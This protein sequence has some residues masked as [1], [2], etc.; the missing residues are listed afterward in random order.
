MIM[1][2]LVST[3]LISTLSFN[4]SAGDTMTVE[5]VIYDNKA[6]AYFDKSMDVDVLAEGF[7]WAE[8]AF[9]VEQLDAVIFSDISTDKVHSWNEAT[10]LTDYLFPSGHA[11][12][13]K[14]NAWRGSNGLTVDNDGKLVLAQQGNRTM[15]RMIAPMSDPAPEYDFLATA[16][17]GEPLN[18]PNDLIVHSSGDIYFTDP[19]YGHEGFENSPN[20]KLDFFGVFRLTPDNE[21]IAIN[22]ELDKPNGIA[23]S[24][25]ESVLYVSDSE[26][27][28]AHIYALALDKEGDAAKAELFFDGSG[29][30]KDGPGST[31]GMIMH[32]DG[33]LITSIP[34]GIGILSTEGELMAKLALGQVTNLALD[35]GTGYLYITAPKQLLRVKL[36]Q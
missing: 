36:K 7:G 26:H 29:L 31:D 14:G 20:I 24:L 2:T 30:I 6:L 16:F 18:S 12:D 8:G 28:K 23:L 25:D 32:P 33:M 3:L 21:L 4:V 10:G 34:N 27:D 11:P 13:D 19:P 22:R 1:R 15:A 5:P 35:P 9:W 17:E